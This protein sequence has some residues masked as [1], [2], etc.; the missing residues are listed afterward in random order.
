MLK[1]RE[2]LHY[3]VDTRDNDEEIC[4]HLE[5]KEEMKPATI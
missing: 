5:E 4:A 1:W 2:G 3:M